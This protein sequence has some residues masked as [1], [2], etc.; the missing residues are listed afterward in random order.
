M[1]Q[2]ASQSNE[3]QFCI[4]PLASLDFD[5]LLSLNNAHAVE[6]SW[7]TRQEF[8]KL[9]AISYHSAGIAPASALL[10]AMD[11]A[12]SY[13]N[14]NFQWFRARFSEF[15]YVDRVVVSQCLRGKGVARALYEDLFKRAS[16]DQ[17]SVITCEVNLDPPNQ[18]SLSF[19]RC[20]GFQTVGESVLP[21][22]KR[23]QYKL[24]EL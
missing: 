4:E 7:L 12:A 18:A 3:G 17:K 6:L 8:K 1:T 24:K 9:L 20:L 15:I 22:G 11:R 14:W 16:V 19:H 5:G 13:N 2:S 10:I 21:S 23:V